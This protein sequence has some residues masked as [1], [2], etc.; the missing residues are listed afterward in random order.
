MNDSVIN[1]KKATSKI[2]RYNWTAQDKPGSVQYI[3]KTLLK[4]H[5]SYQ[6]NVATKKVLNMASS[7]SYIACG[8]IIVGNRGGEYW[9]VDGQH[10]VLA[11]CKRSDIDALPCLVFDTQGVIQEAIGF[12][13]TNTLRKPITSMDKFRAKLAALDDVALYVNSLFDE[14][15]IQPKATASNPM[16]IKSLNWALTKASC[17]KE[18]FTAVIRLAAEICHNHVLSEKLLDGLF[19]IH[20]YTDETLCDKRLRSRIKQIGVEALLESANRAAAYYTKG[21]AKVW[22]DGM[23]NAINKGL[24]SVFEFNTKL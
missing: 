16:E 2:D 11:A 15:G 7:W 20:K 9:V 1:G 12:L 5:P 4:M 24:R 13:K 22:A 14:L 6:R 8:C 10:R 23:M 3:K 17:D 21:G 18:S 19:Y